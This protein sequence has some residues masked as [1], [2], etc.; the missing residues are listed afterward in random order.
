MSFVGSSRNSVV[1][2]SKDSIYATYTRKKSQSSVILDFFTG[3]GSDLL[4]QRF[5]QRF[6]RLKSYNLSDE[7]KMTEIRSI[8]LDWR[9]SLGEDEAM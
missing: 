6:E 9:R 2:M 4:S 3:E 7:A 5:V 1:Y 8:I